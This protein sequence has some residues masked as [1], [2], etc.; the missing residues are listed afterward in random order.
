[1]QLSLLF[2]FLCSLAHCFQMSV[3]QHTQHAANVQAMDASDTS[4]ISSIT[5]YAHFTSFNLSHSCL[6]PFLAFLD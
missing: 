6:L 5:I 3:S 4:R 2:P 1:M